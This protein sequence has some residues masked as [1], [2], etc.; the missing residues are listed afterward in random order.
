MSIVASIKRL[1]AR[2]DEAAHERAAARQVE[3]KSERAETD[4]GVEGLAA[5]E[6][7]A[8]SMAEGSIQDVDRLGE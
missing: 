6:Q 2:R 7:A 1:I 5:D 4:A 3:S 8:R